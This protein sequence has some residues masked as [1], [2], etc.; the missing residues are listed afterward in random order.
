[1]ACEFSRRSEKCSSL[2]DE[3]F[4][5]QRAMRPSSLPSIGHTSSPP[6]SSPTFSI[7]DLSFSPSFPALVTNHPSPSSFIPSS[8]QV[9]GG[10]PSYF[11]II[12]SGL[13]QP[14]I[15]LPKSP[16]QKHPIDKH[17]STI[18]LYDF[19]GGQIGNPEMS[20][21]LIYSQWA[22]GRK[23]LP[24]KGFPIKPD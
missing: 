3:L 19:L 15:F 9:V 13:Q 22:C 23:V 1:M 6:L 24:G 2:N 17:S 7:G 14:S 5:S 16:P 8:P 21:P 10:D 11:C 4:L 18:I 12:P 20:D